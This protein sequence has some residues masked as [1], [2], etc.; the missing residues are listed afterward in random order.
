MICYLVTLQDLVYADPVPEGAAHYRI[1][2]KR[3][4]TM[5]LPSLLA[6]TSLVASLMAAAPAWA[7]DAGPNDGSGPAIVVTATPFRH[8]QDETPS[9]PAKV[10]TQQIRQAGG[11]SIADALKDVPGVSA[12]GFAQGASRPIIRGM[13]SNRV[14]LLEDGTSISDVSDI[15]PDHGTPIDPL[16][17]RSIEVVRGRPLCA[18]V[19]RRSAG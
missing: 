9:I 11:A 8:T 13:D 4:E 7:A 3:T 15:G 2:I 1:G 19:A 12:S 14:R 5:K 18:M 6:S 16:S 10:D 17:A